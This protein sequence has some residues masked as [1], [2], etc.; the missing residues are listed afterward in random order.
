MIDADKS[1]RLQYFVLLWTR[2][3]VRGQPEV[4]DDGFL[5]MTVCCFR[6]ARESNVDVD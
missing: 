2:R 5:P 6:W 4:F 3:A 1:E